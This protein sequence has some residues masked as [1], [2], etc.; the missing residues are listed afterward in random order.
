MLSTGGRH[1]S[2]SDRRSC[3]SAAWCGSSSSE[4][5]STR[6][7]EAGSWAS[8]ANQG[9][10]TRRKDE[11]KW[12]TTWERSARMVVLI[13][14]EGLCRQTF[15]DLGDA[16]PSSVNTSTQITSIIYRSLNIFSYLSNFFWRDKRK[17]HIFAFWN[18]SC[19]QTMNI[20]RFDDEVI[21][22]N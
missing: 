11:E 1:W 2:W 8:E 13:S 5:S 9:K 4:R 7:S 22:F 18:R 19:L 3:W 21:F 15:L 6:I 17:F 10:K 12:K 20:F 16:K 14:G